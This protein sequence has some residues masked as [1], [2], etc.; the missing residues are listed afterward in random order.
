MLSLLYWNNSGPS[1]REEG[2]MH[3]WWFGATWSSC[4]LFNL[5]GSSRE[6]CSFRIVNETTYAPSLWY[7]LCPQQQ[8]QWLDLLIWFLWWPCVRLQQNQLCCICFHTESCIDV[9]LCMYRYS[10]HLYMIPYGRI[11][12]QYRDS[13]ATENHSFMFRFSIKACH[14]ITTPILFLQC[15]VHSCIKFCESNRINSISI[16]GVH[17]YHAFVSISTCMPSLPVCVLLYLYTVIWAPVR[18]KN[19]CITMAISWQHHSN[20]YQCLLLVCL[21]GVLWRQERQKMGNP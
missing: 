13:N 11:I 10:I 8:L 21:C 3:L 18:H 15:T 19:S 12:M 17:S 1:Y 5:V 2:W 14:A 9:H 7:F 6:C 4:F 20:L 16:Y